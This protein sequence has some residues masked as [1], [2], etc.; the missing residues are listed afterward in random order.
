MLQVVSSKQNLKRAKKMKGVWESDPMCQR[1]VRIGC[2]VWP[3]DSS[4]HP[5]ENLTLNEYSPE[6]MFILKNRETGWFHRHLHW[7]RCYFSRFIP[8]FPKSNSIVAKKWSFPEDLIFQQDSFPWRYYSRTIG[9]LTGFTWMTNCGCLQKERCWQREMCICF[10]TRAV[11]SPPPLLLQ[12][13]NHWSPLA[14]CNC[15]YF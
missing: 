14:L 15:L 8:S 10:L 11:L 3:G 4:K 7:Q 5:P 9:S 1:K 12:R 13:G 6:F 2:R